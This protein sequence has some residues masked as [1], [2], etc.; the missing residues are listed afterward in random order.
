MKS[1]WITGFN[2]GE[3]DEIQIEYWKEKLNPQEYGYI[4]TDKEFLVV[5]KEFVKNVAEAMRFKQKLEKENEK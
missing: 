3:I 5:K 2:V 1:F 4:E